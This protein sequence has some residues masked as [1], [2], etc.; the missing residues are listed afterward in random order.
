MAPPNGD[1][2]RLGREDF[3]FEVPDALVAQQPS[4]RRELARLLVR[5]AN[6]TVSHRTISDIT[7]ELPKGSLLIFN[8]SRVIPSRLFGTLA[9]GGK[10]EVFLLKKT[11]DGRTWEALGRPLRK[12]KPGGTINFPGG[13]TA[14]CVERREESVVI[15]FSEE[16]AGFERW[17][18]THG[19]IPLPP[20]IKRDN[21]LPAGESA[22][23]ERYQTVYAKEAGSV[24]APTA[25]LHFTPAVLAAL[26]DNEVETARVCLH[27]G[28]GTF[29]PV[30]VDD[31]GQHPMHAETY[32]VPLVTLQKIEAA[33]L[34]GRPIIAVGT[35]T[36]RSLESFF[37]RCGGDESRL[38]DFANQWFS[39]DLFLRPKHRKDRYRPWAL[40]GLM[41]N[42]HQPYS[43]LYML[44]CALIGYDEAISLY[45]LAVGTEYRL[46]SYGDSS[47]LWLPRV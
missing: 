33:R 14:I 37:L 40:D 8:D 1:S 23:R 2:T 25:G 39:T 42:F 41:T 44:I 11:V 28:G 19:Y 22:D 45:K 15:A 27:V 10:V 36:L 32:N 13:M 21:P 12:I 38:A 9:T 26:A 29:L 4:A 47:L 20:Y 43:T 6:G 3:G 35:T 30:K 7:S 24:A 16:G 46:F 5:Q 18:E 34:D 17:I 31:L